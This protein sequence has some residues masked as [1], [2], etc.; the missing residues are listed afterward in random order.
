MDPRSRAVAGT[1]LLVALIPG[2]SGGGGGGR[3][4]A[5][6]AGADAVAVGE[7]GNAEIDVLANDEDADG[8]V[9]VVNSFTQGSNGAV[10]PAGNGRLRYVPAQHWSGTDS[11]GYTVE[12]GNGGIAVGRVDVSVLAVNDDPASLPD[13]AGTLED[14]PVEIDVLGNDTDVEGDVLAVALL[15]PAAFGSVTLTNAGTVLYAPDENFAGSDSFF[16]VVEDAAGGMAIGDVAVVIEAVDDPPVASAQSLVTG[17]DVPVGVTVSGVDPDGEALTFSLVDGPSS[18]TLTGT[19][20]AVIYHPAPD[21]SGVVSFTF[22]VSD[23]QTVSAPAEVSIEI[24]AVNDAPVAYDASASTI[25]AEPVT[26]PLVAMDVEGSPL[27]FLPGPAASGTVVLG[28]SGTVVYTPAAGFVGTDAF[29]FSAQDPSGAGDVGRVTV[30]VEARPI[31]RVS[32]GASGQANAGAG[33]PAISPDGQAVAFASDSDNLVVGDGNGM[34]DVF[35]HD[36]A[37]GATSLVSGASGGIQ[38]NGGSESPAIAG[39][40]PYSVAFRSSADNLLSVPDT[41]GQTDVFV[42]GGGGGPFSSVELVSEAFDGAQA[43]GFNTAP[44]ISEDGFVIAFESFAANLVAGDTNGVGDIF[45]KTMGGTIVRASVADDESESTGESFTPSVSADGTRVAF[46][47]SGALAPGMP[48][49]GSDIYV[50]DLDDG[51]T[52]RVTVGVGGAGADGSSGNPSISADGRYVAF[53]SFATNLVSDDANGEMDVFVHDLMTGA[54]ERI[55]VGV[56]GESN[57]F[58]A[59]PKISGDGRF[60]TFWSPA[61]NLVTDDANQNTDIFVRDRLTGRTAL[62]SRGWSGRQTSSFSSWSTISADG[63]FIAFISGGHDLVPGD[64]NGAQ[65]VFVVPNPFHP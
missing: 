4:E 58:S 18:G 1:I 45:V 36:R 21:E 23:G 3:N 5:P 28:T 6:T 65:D 43:T 32:V 62:V 13:T 47:S 37:S 7:D 35:V 52:V 9:L 56:G 50:R 64:T 54:T 55:S 11:F 10:T 38:A 25:A 16:Y 41:N 8:D 17:E 48:S 24:V 61:S 40:P 39:G 53:E 12:D 20:P 46:T 51:T 19:L 29:D 31:E 44:S 15:A 14:V 57:G 22:E 60:V 2:C 33:I 27:T 26:I 63:R 34:R 30:T 49:S 42:G 59:A